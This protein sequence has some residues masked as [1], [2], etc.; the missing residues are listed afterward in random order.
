MSSAEIWVLLQG[1]PLEFTWG[2]TQGLPAL[3]GHLKQVGYMLT[4]TANPNKPIGEGTQFEPKR[5]SITK[6]EKS[7]W[8]IWKTLTECVNKNNNET[9][10][11]QKQISCP[12]SQINHSQPP[13]HIHSLGCIRI[14]VIYFA[15]TPTTLTRLRDRGLCFFRHGELAVRPGCGTK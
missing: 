2:V 14:L 7:M 10:M 4:I 6:N 15:K 8:S 3:E 11:F 9:S 13:T 5:A 1:I 12:K